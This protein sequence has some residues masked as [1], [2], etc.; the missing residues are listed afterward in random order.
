[1]NQEMNNRIFKFLRCYE[2]VTQ[3][4]ILIVIYHW[5]ALLNQF[6]RRS[7]VFLW[8]SSIVIYEFLIHNI[9]IKYLCITSCFRQ[10]LTLNNY[11][12]CQFE[13]I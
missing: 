7:V 13:I 1:M 8:R 3:P 10:K 5:K 12:I 11:R 6:L 9:L 4:A 2:Q